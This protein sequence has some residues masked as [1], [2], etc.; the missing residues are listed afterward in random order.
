MV[1]PEEL[2]YEECLEIAVPYLGRMVGEFTEW[3]PLDGRGKYFPE[4]LD[5]KSPW[6]LQ[7]IR[8]RQY[9]GE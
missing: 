7:N 9:P 4:K 3:T 8:S 1:E 5:V 6:Q 2:D